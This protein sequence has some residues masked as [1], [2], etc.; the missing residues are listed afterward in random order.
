MQAFLS[1]DADA[2][3]ML[4]E[5]VLKI[6]PK[7]TRKMLG[8]LFI[9]VMVLFAAVLVVEVYREGFY[10]ILNRSFM[11]LTFIILFIMIQSMKMKVSLIS[12][13]LEIRS[14]WM[15]H[16][17]PVSDIK[18]VNIETHDRSRT[19]WW[20]RYGFGAKYR[21]ARSYITGDAER[22]LWFELYS[23]DP[24]FVSSERPE[25]LMNAVNAAIGNVSV[26]VQN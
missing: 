26:Q 25:E 7:R 6:Y 4:H 5:E 17:V 3:D 24:F 2:A 8:I 10:G 15:K 20:G 19:K 23:G 18:G 14:W 16:T 21:D 1:G 13:A 22:G 11:L 12:E 9:T